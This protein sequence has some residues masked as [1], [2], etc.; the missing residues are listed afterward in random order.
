MIPV[1]EQCGQPINTEYEEWTVS[2]DNE[3]IH[4]DCIELR[5]GGGQVNEFRQHLKKYDE[6]EAKAKAYDDTLKTL[7]KLI[8]DDERYKEAR[9]NDFIAG[10]LIAYE[11]IFNLMEDYIKERCEYDA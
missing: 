5:N 7:D 6:Y 9:S 2:E 10:M 11:N 4:I 3:P 1:C 8:N